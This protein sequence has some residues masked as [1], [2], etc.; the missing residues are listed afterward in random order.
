MT[1][2]AEWIDAIGRE[3]VLEVA[4]ALGLKTAAARGAA[5]GAFSCPACG[6]ERRH[7]SRRDRRLAVGVRSEGRG[8]RCYQCDAHGDQLHLV[9]FALEGSR[10]DRLGPER[11][12]RV[13]TWISEW[14]RLGQPPSSTPTPKRMELRPVDAPPSY[15]P[16]AEV[17]TLWARAL[18]VNRD[19]RASEWLATRGLSA[20]RLAQLDLCR[21]LPFGLPCP[22]WAGRP[23]LEAT[24]DQPARDA[25]P[26]SRSAYRCLF[27]LFDAQGEMRSV[28]ARFVG[29]PKE[30]RPQKFTALKSRAP[31]GFERRGLVLADV[32]GV[33]LLRGE[34]IE[35]PLR[36][37]ITEGEMDLC[38]W[39]GVGAALEGESR[40]TLG[41]VAGS[42]TAAH[43]ARVPDGATVVVATH[44]DEGGERYAQ[45]IVETFE[46]RIETGAIRVVRWKP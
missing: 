24:E 10:F 42:W 31:H 32:R 44:L 33:S 18:R 20:L 15:P 9:A 7:P 21:V 45:Q 35:A 34:P 29:T 43:A 14:L 37:V 2:R 40:A 17:E 11:K 46:Q 8:W 22:P 26:W 41:V 28:L 16:R 4:K 23:A 1:V 19:A 12:M 27:P 36:V 13:R 30:K 6:A 38:S 39:S 25:Q 5:G 3:H